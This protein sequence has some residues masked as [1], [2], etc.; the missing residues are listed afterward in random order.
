MHRFALHRSDKDVLLERLW[1]ELMDLS[2]EAKIRSSDDCDDDRA[3]YAA[4]VGRKESLRCESLSDPY[5][6]KLL[7]LPRLSA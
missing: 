5:L 3:I 4:G 6:T 1:R 2:T 7:V